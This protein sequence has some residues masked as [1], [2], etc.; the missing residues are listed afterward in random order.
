MR[1]SLIP[2]TV[3]ACAMAA[4]AD[5]FETTTEIGIAAELVGTDLVDGIGANRTYRIWAV[6]PENWRLE[7][8]AGNTETTMRFEVIGGTFY[9]SGFG[10]PTSTSINSAFFALAPELEWDSYLTIGA[11]TSSNNNLGNIGIDFD[12]FEAG[13]SLLE[14]NNGTVFITIDDSQGDVTTFLDACGRSHSGALIAQFTLVGEGASLE[15]SALLQGR[16]A[17][18][19]TVQAHITAFAIDADGLS[20]AL[21]EAACAADITGDEQVD[22]V[23][24]LHLL[25]N[26][27]DDTCE[28]ITG[29]LLVGAADVLLL[30]NSWG[31]CP[32][33]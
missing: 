16:N 33:G 4:S 6:T 15:G 9:Q 18:G 17:L 32:S 3:A 12:A 24:L 23:D 27:N 2:M 19:V 22:V 7:V 13:G 14:S 11:L 29:D 28:D 1:L 21:P 5:V 10:G 8:V 26:W 30:I 20:D 25:G 31:A